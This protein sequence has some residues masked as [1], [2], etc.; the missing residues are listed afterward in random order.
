MVCGS[1][2]LPQQPAQRDHVAMSKP[3]C[4]FLFEHLC[5]YPTCVSLSPGH[6][7]IACSTMTRDESTG[8]RQ[9][10]APASCGCL[11]IQTTDHIAVIH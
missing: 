8:T 9:N 7:H 5:L 3:M 4:T 10:Q 6:S 1:G 2:R 11:H